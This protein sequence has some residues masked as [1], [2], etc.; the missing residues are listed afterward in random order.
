MADLLAALRQD[1]ALESVGTF[2]LD[3][4]R[5]LEKMRQFQ[6]PDPHDYVLNL[7]QAGVAL[8]AASI[9]CSF[10][11]GFMDVRFIGVTLAPE[12]LREPLA[13]L[14]L[15]QE[16]KDLHGYRELAIGL[17]A[18][19]SI[20]SKGL[21]LSSGSYRVQVKAYEPGGLEP[22]KEAAGRPVTR[23]YAGRQPLV[24]RTPAL[25][26]AAL[27][28]RAAWCPVPLE[29][30]GVRVQPRAEVRPWLQ[31]FHGETGR[32]EVWL[33]GRTS[34]G[35]F[36]QYGVHVG[37]RS[38]SLD[39]PHPRVRIFADGITK[40]ASSSDIIEDDHYQLVLADVERASDLLVEAMCKTDPAAKASV[41]VSALASRAG[42][43]TPVMTDVP[44]FRIHPQGRASISNLRG[45]LQ[46]GGYLF[47]AQGGLAMPWPD[48]L[49]L[50][51][52]TD[53][54]ETN[55]L[56]LLFP[57]VVRNAE[58]KE[59]REASRRG[60]RP[61]P[62]GVTHGR[63]PRS[64]L[65]PG[66]YAVIVPFEEGGYQGELGVCLGYQTA[67]A[68]AIVR[69][70]VVWKELA[71]PPDTL[72]YRA[73]VRNDRWPAFEGEES[74]HYDECVDVLERI[75]YQACR[76]GCQQSDRHAADIRQRLR[77]WLFRRCLEGVGA[78]TGLS[79]A[80]R[81]FPLFRTATGGVASIADLERDVEVFGGPCYALQA[82]PGPQRDERHVVVDDA[83]LLLQL[84]PTA[85]DDKPR[86]MREREQLQTH[87]PPP[88]PKPEPP[89]PEPLPVPPPLPAL[90]LPAAAGDEASG[91]LGALQA[92]LQALPERRD[93]GLSDAR[94]AGLQPGQADG[95]AV[96]V[97]AH[98]VVVDPRH[99]DV[100]ASVARHS[101]LLLAL[102][103][104]DA[105]RRAE[106]D[107]SDEAEYRLQ[108]ALARAVSERLSG[109]D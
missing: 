32:I 94:V 29:V 67:P 22:Q 23:M 47:V 5:A 85:V 10:W 79:P 50:V 61:G 75:F 84:F 103:V 8:G 77:G 106:P 90:Q 33:D 86:L 105:V 95:H 1:G 64:F 101:V 82:P 66:E 12:V 78:R 19:L 7:V 104:V 31:A 56:H 9:Q 102:L 26:T 39:S 2:T 44:V 65:P 57:G 96:Q 69:D 30:N 34:H 14:F 93:C 17:N 45:R 92:C 46:R 43:L 70:G 16:H 53:W 55:S 52:T 60:G 81:D 59:A 25:E 48:D 97:L 6:L 36:V 63:A 73:W 99:P 15:S 83:M 54:A 98:G 89:A 21:V 37:T 38:L 27:F 20:H 109:S 35:D 41:I 74:P 80:L 108:A 76:H 71:L 13:G 51:L 18:A 49:P 62:P 87:P 11:F 91:L 100:A 24:D 42:R 68:L 107:V 28:R 3:R 40:N 88:A 72:P 4:A 58:D